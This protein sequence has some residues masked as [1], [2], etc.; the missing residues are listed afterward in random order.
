MI[1]RGHGKVVENFYGKSVGTMSLLA[2][3]ISLG[4]CL[5]DFDAAQKLS[6][7]VV[8]KHSWKGKLC[9]LLKQDILKV[10]CHF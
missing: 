5:F 3:I 6:L 8:S 2:L 9:G 7:H 1:L 10:I 4:F